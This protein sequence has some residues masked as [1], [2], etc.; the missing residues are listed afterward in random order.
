MVQTLLFAVTFAA[1]GATTLT[2]VR[3][4]EVRAAHA[5]I[6][7]YEDDVTDRLAQQGLAN[8]IAR[9]RSHHEPARDF[10]LEDAQGHVVAG[11]F[12]A[13]PLPNP[14][15]PKHKFWSS[16]E[17]HDG[18]PSAGP[19]LAYTRPEPGGLRLTAGEYLR[20]REAQDNAIMLA[21]AGLAAAVAGVGM[22]GGVLVSRGVLRRVDGMAQSIERYAGGDREARIERPGRGPSDL[23]ELA[24]AL[25]R[26]M[27]R[28]NR[29][30]EGLRQVSSSIA[31]DLRRPLAHH[32]QEI[33]RALAGPST[34][35]NFRSAL[36]GA[37]ERVGEVLE[38]FQALL[39]IAEL[40][41]GA[42]GLTLQPVDLDEIAGKIVDAYAP[43]A[44]AEGRMLNFSPSGG[45]V[46]IKAEPR[47]LGQ[48]LANLV[49]N[50]LRHTPAGTQVQIRV[51]ASG[52][53]IIVSD[54]GP[55]VP[56]AIRGKIFDRFF[57][58][59]ASRSTPGSG[60]GLA[61]ATAAIGAFGGKLTAEDAGPG[62]RLVAAFSMVP[63]SRRPAA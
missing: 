26:M 42:P 22:V 62:L 16:Y 35:A 20:V 32:N 45:S 54:N 38:T 52:P 53:R 28:E 19:L 51:E 59:D 7:E 21:I 31:H 30:V 55:G 33:G 13:P 12:P 4:G 2:V 56:D 63:S 5:E 10:R 24:G 17:L 11:G 18:S 60:L 1:A 48:A 39:H 3:R 23:D 41:A 37:S 44:E 25:N 27:D 50:A 43:L 8:L 29:L 15:P 61:L 49:E 58:Q 34:T 46:E 47:I 36:I 9:S 40:E 6:E 14:M 57:R